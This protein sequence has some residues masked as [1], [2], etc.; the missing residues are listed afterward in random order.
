MGVHLS[1]LPP[2]I[3]TVSGQQF[4]LILNKACAIAHSGEME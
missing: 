4:N 3:E 2:D 1:L